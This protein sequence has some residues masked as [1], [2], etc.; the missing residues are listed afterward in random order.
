MDLPAELR[1]LPLNCDSIPV[2]R[3]SLLSNH[4]SGQHADQGGND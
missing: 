4:R 3:M 2:L 1:T